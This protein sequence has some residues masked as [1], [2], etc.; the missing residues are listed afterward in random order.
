MARP[1][2][3]D[4]LVLSMGINTLL[5]CVRQTEAW[6]RLQ[7]DAAS[8][9]RTRLLIHAILATRC[10]FFTNTDSVEA[11]HDITDALSVADELRDAAQQCHEGQSALH[12]RLISGAEAIERLCGSPFRRRK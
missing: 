7:G 11:V 1:S 6:W 2:R 4:M 10:K 3:E 8:L 9:R 5:A 12:G